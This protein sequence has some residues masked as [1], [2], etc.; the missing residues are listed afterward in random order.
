MHEWQVQAIKEGITAAEHS[1]VVDFE[2]IKKR[3]EKSLKS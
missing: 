3:W 1:E 2:K